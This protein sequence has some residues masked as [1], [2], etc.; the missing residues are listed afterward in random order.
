MLNPAHRIRSVSPRAVTSDYEVCVRLSMSLSTAVAMSWTSRECQ[1]LCA[2]RS[3]VRAWQSGHSE[4]AGP[5]S[6]VFS[7]ALRFLREIVA[8]PP[9]HGRD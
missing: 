5:D 9:W 1:C 7:M 8:L 3:A 4:E 2:S 6:A